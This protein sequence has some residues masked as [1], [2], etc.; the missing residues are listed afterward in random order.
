MRIATLS[1]MMSLG[2][3]AAVRGQGMLPVVEDTAPYRVDSGV[4]RNDGVPKD[5]LTVLFSHDVHREGVAWLRLHFSD[6]RLGAGS[7]LRMTSLADGS[8]QWLDRD[9]VIAWRHGSAYFNGDT[10][11]LELL[12]APGTANRAVLEMISFQ[13]GAFGTDGGCGICEGDD[14]EPSTDTAACRLLPAGC[15]ATVYSDQSCIVTA[16]HC[17]D[18]GVA[19]VVEFNVPP[20]NPDCSLAHPPAVDQFPVIDQLFEN[21]G[22]GNDWGVLRAGTNTDGETPWQRF[23][24]LS[25]ISNDP[26]VVTEAVTVFGYGVDTQCVRN[27]VQQTSGGVINSISGQMFTHD[28]DTTFGNSGS[29]MRNDAGEIIGIATNCGCPT[30]VAM[31]IDA[32]D[33]AEARNDICGCLGDINLDGEVGVIDLLKVLSQWGFT[34]EQSAD[35]NNDSIVDVADLLIVLSEWGPC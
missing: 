3:T 4:V 11:R 2:L 26:P 12:G 15:S 25:P 13:A 20:S 31:R 5:G 35:V 19:D 32:S 33:F 8:T 7:G 16:G 30:N 17:V 21:I 10:V 1:I 22:I 23:G 6:L 18:G 34:G 9:G 28:A 29:G 24:A 14:R 27:Q